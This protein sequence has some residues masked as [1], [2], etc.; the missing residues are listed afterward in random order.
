MEMLIFVT[1]AVSLRLPMIVS[2]RGQVR[3]LTMVIIIRTDLLHQFVIYAV[4]SNVNADNFKWFGTQPGDMALSL[5]LIADLWRV[6]I[7]QGSFFSAVCFFILDAAVEGLGFLGLQ[8]WLWRWFKLNHLG[9]W[10]QA[11]RNISQTRGV[12]SEINTEGPIA[13]INDFPCDQEV[14]LNSFDVRVEVAP[15]KHFL[16]FPGFYYRSAFSSC[17]RFLNLRDVGQP[18]PKVFYAVW[19]GHLAMFQYWRWLNKQA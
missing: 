13:V 1:D 16:E 11:Y 5:L 17:E 9:R 12:M 2:A 3:S 4:K 6:E 18:I 8:C 15:S 14:E 19:V 10:H 7:A